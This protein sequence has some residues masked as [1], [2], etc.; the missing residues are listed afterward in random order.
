MNPTLIIA[1]VVVL[2]VLLGALYYINKTH[3][4][5]QPDTSTPPVITPPTTDY[6]TSTPPVINPPATST[7]PITDTPV[8]NTPVDIYEQTP[9]TPDKWNYYYDPSNPTQWLVLRRKDGQT[10]C[11]ADPKNPSQCVVLK[12][13]IDA[14]DMVGA[15]INFDVMMAQNK[16]P[17]PLYKTLS[18]GDEYKKYYSISGY[19]QGPAHWCNMFS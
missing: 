9:R 8:S 4:V 12:N 13:K 7:P 16:Y 15:A 17:V 11:F 3:P 14:G 19:D 18:C 6:D 2:V 5:N 1:A 10:Q